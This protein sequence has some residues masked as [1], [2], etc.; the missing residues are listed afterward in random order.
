MAANAR[1]PKAWPY[2]AREAAESVQDRL[3]E[4][5]R[6]SRQAQQALSAGDTHRAVMLLGDIREAELVASGRLAAALRGEY[7][8]G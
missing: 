6:L 5:R 7:G 4:I 1:T 3:M 8:E 2:K